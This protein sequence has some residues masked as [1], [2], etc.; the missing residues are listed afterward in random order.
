MGA[1]SWM[2]AYADGNPTEILQSNPTLDRQATTALAKKLFPSDKLRPLDDSDL[3]STCPPDDE[4]RIA[5]FPGLS[6]VAAK[7][8]GIDF[9]SQL[10]RNFVEAGAG[11]TIY[12]HAMHSVVDW[13]AFAIWINGELTR[14]LSLSP[15][16]GIIEDI[17]PK[18]AFEKPYWAGEHQ[19]FDEA[20]EDFAYPF[21]FH[22]LELAE[23]ALL[24]FFGY[25][26]EGIITSIQPET[27][28][29][30]SLKRMK[31]KWK[32]W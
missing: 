12:L 4:I 27:I 6:I 14:S 22:P 16:S 31:P 8:F 15:D 10:G 23:A 32:F 13:M 11:K 24:E 20:D 7:E 3:L 29:L 2:L 17:G 1:K 5:C 21:P 19:V 18:L 30:A 28:P 9:P 26:L 25:H